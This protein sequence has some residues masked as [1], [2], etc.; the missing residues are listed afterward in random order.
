[1]PFP[2][3]CRWETLS[4]NNFGMI[5]QNLGMIA[6]HWRDDQPVGGACEH[7]RVPSARNCP[8]GTHSIGSPVQL[9]NRDL[10]Y[11]DY[12]PEIDRNRWRAEQLC[13]MSLLYRAR[14]P[15]ILSSFKKYNVELMLVPVAMCES[16]NEIG[17]TI[18]ACQRDEID[19]IRAGAGFIE[20]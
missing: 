8:P 10:S 20:K 4:Q 1:M 7:S 2:R 14:H 5:F 11:G 17:V 13:L 3:D 16:K 19:P 15:V 12:L 6:I 18:A 9:F